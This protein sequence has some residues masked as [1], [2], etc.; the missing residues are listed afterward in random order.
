VNEILSFFIL[1]L[2][3]TDAIGL[4]IAA[5]S[6]DRLPCLHCPAG[7]LDLEQHGRGNQLALIRLAALASGVYLF[8]R[9]PR[10]S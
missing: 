9:L 4:P 8:L 10:L 6:Q 5:A 2:G 7:I 3:I 1:T